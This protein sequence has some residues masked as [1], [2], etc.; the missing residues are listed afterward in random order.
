MESQGLTPTAYKRKKTEWDAL[1]TSNK[2]DKWFAQHPDAYNPDT[3]KLYFAGKTYQYNPA[4][5]PSRKLQLAVFN[6]SYHDVKK[7]MP[8]KAS[9]KRWRER[10]RE[11]DK[12]VQLYRELTSQS[13]LKKFY[14]TQMKTTK[15]EGEQVLGAKGGGRLSLD[16]VKSKDF[17]GLRKTFLFEKRLKEEM[18]DKSLKVWLDVSFEVEDMAKKTSL[19]NQRSRPYVVHTKDEVASVLAKMAL[20]MQLT[21][22]EKE[23]YKSGL[24]LKGVKHMTLHYATYTPLGGAE[25]LPLPDCVANTKSCVNVKNEDKYCFKYAMMCAVHEVYKKE[26][27]PRDEALQNPG[28]EDKPQV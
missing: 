8:T 27:P 17:R 5:H 2:L 7:K 9:L 13:A 24:T 12:Q 11:L 28:G 6:A 23:L 3:K 10:A 20:E 16:G 14:E 21:F 15:T 25:Y 22:E 26:K 4:K 18:K 19:F 1:Q